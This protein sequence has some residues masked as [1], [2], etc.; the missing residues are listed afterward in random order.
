MRLK[1]EFMKCLVKKDTAYT[2]KNIIDD[3]LNHIPPPYLFGVSPFHTDNVLNQHWK[4]VESSQRSRQQLASS[5]ND[6]ESAHEPKGPAGRPRNH[7]HGVTTETRKDPLRWES[8][9]AGFIL[10]QLSNMGWREPHLHISQNKGNRP[11]DYTNS[12]I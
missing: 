8:Q 1:K 4:S 9:S 3:M 5:S 11:N 10:A 7:D 6:R 2:T 12:T